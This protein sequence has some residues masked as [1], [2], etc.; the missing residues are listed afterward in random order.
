MLQEIGHHFKLPQSSDP[1]KH[2]KDMIYLTQVTVMSA[3]EVAIC[4]C[5][6]KF[7][8]LLE[9]DLVPWGVFHHTESFHTEELESP[10]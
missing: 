5:S 2:F 9:R 4:A 7:C 6:I 10:V 1:V 3:I 8:Q